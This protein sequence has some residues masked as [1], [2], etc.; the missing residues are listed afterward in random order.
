[1]LLGLRAV[2]TLGSRSSALLVVV[3]RWDHRAG[4]VFGLFRGMI[5]YLTPVIYRQVSCQKTVESGVQH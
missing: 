4:D 1:M 2:N 5:Y 3:T